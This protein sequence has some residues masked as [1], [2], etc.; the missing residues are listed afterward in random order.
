[1][2][3]QL[4]PAQLEKQAARR[5]AKEAKAAEAAAQ[6]ASGQPV[7]VVNNQKL[8]PEEIERRKVL[9]REWVPVTTT[10]SALA[11]RGDR[12]ARIV[13][14]NLLAQTL[15]RRE[16]FP[17][18]DCL[19]WGERKPMLLAEL[20]Y[21]SNADIVC[22]QECD[23]LK[24]LCR[25]MPHHLF[26]EAKGHGKLH[27]LV[28]MY[29]SSRY[30]VRAKKTVFLDEEYLH[31]TKDS[32]PTS[33]GSTRDEDEE[34]R[35]RAG[36]RHTKNIGLI[37]ALEDLEKPDEG[38]VVST[39][40]LFWH[41]KYA[42]ERVRQS[43]ILLRNIVSFKNE[44]GAPDWPAVIS[45][46]FNTQ[47]DEA[48]YQIIT[49]PHQ[50]TPQEILRSIDDSRFIHQSLAKVAQSISATDEASVPTSTSGTGS[51]T[52]TQQ[53][54]KDDEGEEEEPAPEGTVPGTRPAQASDGIPT[55]QELVEI[56]RQLLP[57]GG[58]RSAY[59]SGRWGDARYTFGGRN[60]FQ[61]SFE[62][63][64]P[65]GLQGHG[66]AAYTCY[67]PLF[68]LS[69]DYLFML[70]SPAVQVTQVLRPGTAEEL[71]EG[72]PRKGIS[73]SDHLAVGC[74]ITW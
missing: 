10:G 38:I 18:S 34:R 68:K 64:V 27:G 13:T 40:H 67:T 25:A 21:Y 47:P 9:R 44:H 39:A 35:R 70:P 8:S 37:V 3:I 57:D 73:A 65:D 14:W 74:E 32:N 19:R 16:L 71:G 69:L 49:A 60:G 63:K 12:R 31:D 4:T 2:S 1:M 30:R 56:A 48:T 72:L 62:G 33:E 51:N 55:S 59:T 50:A 52:P 61:R 17:G 11:V 6:A 66:E 45:G 28:V 42:Y 43:L 23:R 5:A 46:D 53:Q 58:C 7:S 24:D 54:E 20:E 29:R 22:F 15:V 41:P 36:T 26:V